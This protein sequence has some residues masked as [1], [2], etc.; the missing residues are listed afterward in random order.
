MAEQTDITEITHQLSA[1]NSAVR[2]KGLKDLKLLLNLTP[3]VHFKQVAASLHHFYR[4][5]EGLNEQLADR[6]ALCGLLDLVKP[7][8][9][10]KWLEVFIAAI[11]EIWRE[12]E[13]HRIEKYR[14]L[15]QEWF[16]TC[17]GWLDGLADSKK[18]WLKWN[19]FLFTE[20]LFNPEGNLK[21]GYCDASIPAR[22][23]GFL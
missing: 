23:V 22:V 2:H 6:A 10:L 1:S 21:S 12:I 18:T 11:I 9:Q 8:D 20:V 15:M 13:F 4:L 17:Y 7:E 16:F 14:K 19:H 5:S 3:Q